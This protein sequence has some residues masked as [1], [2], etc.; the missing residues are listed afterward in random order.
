MFIFNSIQIFIDTKFY[1]FL[2]LYLLSSSILLMRNTK[3]IVITS[4]I[5]ARKRVWRT[6]DT[7]DTSYLLLTVMRLRTF[8]STRVIT[9]YYPLLPGD[10]YI[11]LS[12]ILHWHIV[13][14]I[15]LYYDIL[16]YNA[17]GLQA[18]SL[19]NIQCEM[20]SLADWPELL[21]RD[22]R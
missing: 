14:Y 4:R 19:Y 22:V 10:Q 20:F 2:S 8:Q 6:V 7:G 11:Q 16:Y 15:I 3:H 1:F 12:V 5:L 13:T 18:I 17:G 21:Y 9:K